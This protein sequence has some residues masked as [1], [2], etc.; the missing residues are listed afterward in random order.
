MNIARTGDMFVFLPPY[1]PVNFIFNGGVLKPAR[2]LKELPL[3]L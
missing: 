3:Q 2:F 1:F